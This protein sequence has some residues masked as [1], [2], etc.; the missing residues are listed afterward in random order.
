MDGN[1]SAS[2]TIESIADVIDFLPGAFLIADRRGYI[3]KFNHEATRLLPAIATNTRLMDLFDY[4]SEWRECLR[5]ARRSNGCVPVAL[6]SRESG[7]RLRA[8]MRAITTRGGRPG[9]HLMIALKTFEEANHRLIM[10]NH[11]LEMARR[12][13]SVLRRQ[14]RALRKTLENTVPRLKELALR[15]PLTKACNRRYFD[16]QIRKEWHRAIR[17][18]GLLSLVYADIDHF[19]EFNDAFGHQQGDECLCAVSD[20]LRSSVHREFDRV[21]RIG[22]EEFAIMLPMTGSTGALRVGAVALRAVR[23]LTIP[24]PENV[25]DT[26]TISVGVGTCRPTVS[27]DPERFIDAVDRAMYDAKAH[28]R[29]RLAKAVERPGGDAESKAGHRAH[30]IAA[31][32]NTN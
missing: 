2:T 26:V 16:R 25:Q 8:S 21:C 29:N 22:G 15:D 12:E 19:K 23:K 11:R 10:L 9:S 24:H 32:D 28:G 5:M 17:Q 1:T 31:I 27:D 4:E 7:D 13:Q 14:N 18:G 3:V 6:H 30:A 20:A